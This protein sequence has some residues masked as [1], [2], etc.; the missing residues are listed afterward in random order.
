[1]ASLALHLPDTLLNPKVTRLR[2]D[3]LLFEPLPRAPLIQGNML[4]R[5]RWETGVMEMSD[6]LDFFQV[7]RQRSFLL[8]FCIPV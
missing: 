6:L 3:R 8:N 2:L 7:W 1:M 4:S 5:Q